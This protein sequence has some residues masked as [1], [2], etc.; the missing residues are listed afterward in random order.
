MNA[1]EA[2][3]R[4]VRARL[5]KQILEAVFISGDQN[6]F[7]SSASLEKAITDKV[8]NDFVIPDLNMFGQI[9]DFPLDA[10][11]YD[12]IDFYTRVY[13]L[14]IEI[15]EGRPIVDGHIAARTITTGQHGLPPTALHFNGSRSSVL[16]AAQKVT[17]SHSTIPST[18]TAEVTILGPSV[19]KIRD[20]GQFTS[21][22]TLRG[23]MGFHDTLGEIKPPFYGDFAKLVEYAVRRYCYVNTSMDLDLTR[24]HHGMEFGA[25]K[26]WIERWSDSDELYEEQLKVMSRCLVLNDDRATRGLRNNGGRWKV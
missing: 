10:V 13:H 7:R 5:P 20:P 19:V 1:I 3:F 26:D 17:M 6:P 15:T 21:Q 18:A 22:M 12:T 14:P 23:R 25:F 11:G 4:H 24:L 8:I 2:A 9:E 16:N